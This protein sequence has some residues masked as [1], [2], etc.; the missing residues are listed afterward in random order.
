MQKIKLLGI[1]K[2]IIF[3]SN[4]IELFILIKD[5]ILFINRKDEPKG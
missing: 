5:G 1:P 2:T 4:D 3:S